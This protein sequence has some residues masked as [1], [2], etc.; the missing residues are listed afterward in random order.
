MMQT[1]STEERRE[2]QSGK[3]LSQGQAQLPE[4]KAALK[5]LQLGDEVVVR[6][7]DIKVAFSNLIKKA[8]PDKGAVQ[9]EGFHAGEVV[10]GLKEARDLLL[11]RIDRP[12]MGLGGKGGDCVII[13]DDD[14]WFQDMQDMECSDGIKSILTIIDEDEIVGKSCPCAKGDIGKECVFCGLS[15]VGCRCFPIT[16][17]VA[18]TAV[19]ED[20]SLTLPNKSNLL[21]QLGKFNEFNCSGSKK[22][23]AK[24]CLEWREQASDPKRDCPSYGNRYVFWTLVVGI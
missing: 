15:W 3:A 23:R 2:G 22:P 18:F 6:G 11:L 5:L 1:N 20:C 14:S 10:T 4:V 21:F 17:D 12:S 13:D 7:K 9:E 8:H 24:S 19:C 16:E